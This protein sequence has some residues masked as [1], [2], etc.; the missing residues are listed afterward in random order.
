LTVSRRPTPADVEAARQNAP[1]DEQGRPVDHR[2]GEP[3]RLN[4]ADGNRGWHM[5]W[6][7]EVNQW[8]AENPGSGLPNAG[9]M[10]PTGDPNSFGYDADGNRMPYA[11]SRPSYADGQEVEVWRAA[12]DDNGQVWVEGP[13]GAPVRIEWTEN[14]PR[15][16]VWDMGHRPGEEYRHLRYRYLNHDPKLPLEEFLKEYRTAAKYQVEHPTVNRSHRNEGP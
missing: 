14:T 13:D 3:L 8:V 2:T 4:D 15:R 7:P 1:V 6:D 5:K 9:D 12:M 16:D 11:N 10:P